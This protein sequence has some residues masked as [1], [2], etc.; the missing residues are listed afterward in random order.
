MRISDWSSDVC[1][2][3]LMARRLVSWGNSDPF[4]K[5]RHAG[6]TRYDGAPMGKAA[7]LSVAVKDRPYTSDGAKTMLLIGSRKRHLQVRWRDCVARTRLEF[8]ME[9]DEV[10]VGIDRKSTRL[11]S[12]H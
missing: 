6:G 10:R 3:D 1:S 2:S 4:G 11:N 8:S 5:S 7:A 9:A 12:S